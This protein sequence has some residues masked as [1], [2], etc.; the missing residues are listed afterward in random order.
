MRGLIPRIYIYIYIQ[1]EAKEDVRTAGSH[2]F[3]LCK[4]EN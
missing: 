1:Y 2:P 3:A 4:E